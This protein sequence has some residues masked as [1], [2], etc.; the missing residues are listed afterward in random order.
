MYK[1][2]AIVTNILA[3]NDLYVVEG[4]NPDNW[5][6]HVPSEEPMFLYPHFILTKQQNE[7]QVKDSI[8]TVS[9]SKF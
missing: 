6:V 8:Y 9:V 5:H 2:V 7:V 4:A 1:K 3:M